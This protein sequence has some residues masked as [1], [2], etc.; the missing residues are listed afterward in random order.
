[1]L[2]LSLFKP[3]NKKQFKDKGFKSEVKFFDNVD[4]FINEYTSSSDVSLANYRN[5][6]LFYFLFCNLTLFLFV[7]ERFYLNIYSA[8]VRFKLIILGLFFEILRILI[9]ICKTLILR[10]TI[11]ND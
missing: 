2:L 10:L 5:I 6:F 7:I 1:M 8:I 11:L 4:A 9:G 3:M